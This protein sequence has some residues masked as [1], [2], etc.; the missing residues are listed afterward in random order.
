MKNL[1]LNK[2][3]TALVDTDDYDWLRK[4]KW[5][6]SNSGYAVR[7]Q[8]I[9]KVNGKYKSRTVLM[10]REIL[11]APK[12]S[13]VDHTNGNR[14]DNRK[15]NIRV[16]T[17]SQNLANIKKSNKTSS[18]PRGVT[19]NSNKKSRKDFVV[20]I[21]KKRKLCFLG[22]YDNLIEAEEA[23]LVN[24]KIIYGEFA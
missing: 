20:R 22:Y 9:G 3:F 1:N 13:D 5:Y 16:C 12:G 21:H 4:N 23:Y 10:H 14:L 11:N 6:V 19:R 17:R 15:S 24:K 2:N 8:Y 7:D 18:L